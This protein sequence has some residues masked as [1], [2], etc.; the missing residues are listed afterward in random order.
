MTR[1]RMPYLLVL[2]STLFL[3]LFF[4]YPMVS[5]LGMSARNDEGGFTWANLSAVFN[6]FQFGP[7]LRTTILLAIIMLPLQFVIGLAM[8]LVVNSRIR[9]AGFFLY[10]YAVP[11][12]VSEV[13]AGIVWTA[14]LTQNGYLNSILQHLGILNEPYLFTAAENKKAVFISVLIAEMWRSTAIVSV[15][16]VS[17]LQS[18]PHE[19][20][21]AAE[22]FGASPFKRL[23]KVTLPMLKGTIQAALIIRAV[24]ALQAFAVVSI[25]GGAGVTT[26]ANESY[27]Q[28]VTYG[29][30]RNAAVLAGLV[31]GMALLTVAILL[32]ALRTDPQER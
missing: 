5:G 24:L 28:Y 13:A 16:L 6:D 9:G 27:K 25:V 29:N 14:M 23:I 17:G 4:G 30:E 21:E 18:I 31:L 8:A 15:M 10:V 32:S 2:P 22:V 7:A 19:Y 1:K 20:H 12:A 11:I 26:L 3:M